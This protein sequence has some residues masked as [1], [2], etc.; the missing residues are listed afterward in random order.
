MAAIDLNCTH[1]TYGSNVTTELLSCHGADSFYQ[2]EAKTSD[3]EML[4]SSWWSPKCCSTKKRIH[5]YWWDTLREHSKGI[6]DKSFIITRRVMGKF[7]LF[8]RLYV[9]GYF[10]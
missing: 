6:Y 2:H 3:L 7:W 10:G 4:A 5:K 9:F 1:N 8:S